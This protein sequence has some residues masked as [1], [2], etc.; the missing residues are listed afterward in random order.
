MKRL[1]AVCAIVL[2][3]IASHAQVSFSSAVDLALRNN[4]RVKMAQADVERTRAILAEAKDVYIPAVSAGS[5]LGYTY[6][7]PIGTPTLY[8]FTVQSLVWD[9]SQFNYI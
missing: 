9:Q 7:F 2:T 8:N 1:L 5:G 3:S 6:G 4:P